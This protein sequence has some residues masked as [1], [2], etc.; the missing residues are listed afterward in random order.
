MSE[1]LRSLVGRMREFAGDRRHV[2]RRR[3][4]LLFTVSP[5]ARRRVNGRRPLSALEGYTRDISTNG[6]G[7]IVPA[8]RIGEHYLAGENCRLLVSL[9][10]PSG[11]IQ[12]HATS[13]R[14]ERLDE[15]ESEDGYLIGARITQMSEEH[16]ERFISYL[17]ARP[18]S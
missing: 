15:N 2:P 14:Y 17:K 9:E 13:A 6:L 10:L 7:L 16:R 12:I 11:S 5:E 3:T 4:R 8:I 1:F 18:S